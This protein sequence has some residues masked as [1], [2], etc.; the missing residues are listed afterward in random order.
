MALNLKELSQLLIK[1]CMLW[2]T[3]LTKWQIYE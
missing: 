3:A 2:K 1:D